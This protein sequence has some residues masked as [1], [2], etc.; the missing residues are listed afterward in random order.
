MMRTVLQCL[1][2]SMLWV[3]A[4][5]A[6]AQNAYTLQA[7]Q[8][9]IARE[10]YG[11]HSHVLL[12]GFGISVVVFAALFYSIV[13][14]RRSRGHEPAKFS[15]NRLLTIT[16]AVIPVLILVAIAFPGT[17]AVFAM[18]DTSHPDVTV[19]ITGYQ[20]KWRYDY[21]S[22]DIGFYSNLSTPRDQIDNGAPKGANYL[23]EVDKPLVVPVGKKIRIL[24]TADDVIHSWWVPAFGVKQDGIPGFVRDSWFTVESPGIYRGQCSELC[25]KDHGFM[26]IVVHAVPEAEYVAWI[27]D[28]QAGKQASTKADTAAAARIYSL[29]E[30]KA[31]G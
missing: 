4:G 16:W 13:R 21:L 26:P 20:W 15:D 11:L 23:L 17:R 6:S 12:I 10:I 28:Q 1:G 7:P 22:E 5:L 18:K 2:G 9:P 25:G 24:V 14:F 27:T 30:L 31:E 19:K 29:A 3:V 8:T